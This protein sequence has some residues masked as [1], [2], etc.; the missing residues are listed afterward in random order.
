MVML[1]GTA[2]RQEIYGR[3][4]TELHDI[5]GIGLAQEHGALRMILGKGGGEVAYITTCRHIK[6]SQCL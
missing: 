5:K 1:F 3:D 4:F 2:S 6:P